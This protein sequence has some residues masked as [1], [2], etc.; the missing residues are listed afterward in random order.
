[1]KEAH[2]ERDA[3]DIPRGSVGEFNS[4]DSSKIADSTDK[5]NTQRYYFCTRMPQLTT[6]VMKTFLKNRVF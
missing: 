2:F 5:L 6:R 3:L 1:M 4:A